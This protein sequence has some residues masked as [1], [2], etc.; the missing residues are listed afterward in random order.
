MSRANP[1]LN[2][3]ELAK[4]LGATWNRMSDSEKSPFQS[5]RKRCACVHEGVRE[6][7]KDK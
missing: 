1:D 3:C 4:R 6:K 7:E 2:M 5:G